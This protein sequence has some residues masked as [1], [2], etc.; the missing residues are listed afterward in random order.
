[1]E[2]EGEGDVWPEWISYS[3]SSFFIFHEGDA[4]FYRIDCARGI[5]FV[6][7]IL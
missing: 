5:S 4:Y 6:N 2:E 7:I 3:V 1:M